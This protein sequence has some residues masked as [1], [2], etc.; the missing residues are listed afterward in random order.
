MPRSSL[1][2]MQLESQTNPFSTFRINA[3]NIEQVRQSSLHALGRLYPYV[4][5]DYRERINARLIVASRDASP[6]VHQGVAMALDAIEGD[7]AL[8]TRLFL[9]LVVLLH[10]PDPEPCSWA[11][12]AAGHLMAHRLAD[13][14]VEDLLERLLNLAETAP[15]VDVRV[16]TAIGLRALAES[17]RLDTTMQKRVLAAL[18]TLSNDVSFR[19]RFN[20]G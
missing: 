5:R 19:V 12:V 6:I 15:V 10:D 3:G 20:A 7:V 14:F 8:P 2:E 11:C 18:A 17:D 16:G 9:A 13:Q 4:D 1:I